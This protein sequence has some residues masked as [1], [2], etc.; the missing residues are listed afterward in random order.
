MKCWM[1]ISTFHGSLCLKEAFECMREF[2]DKILDELFKLGFPESKRSCPVFV[3]FLDHLDWVNDELV[4]PQE[5][6]LPHFHSLVV[7]P[8]K[9]SETFESLELQ[10][11]WTDSHRSADRVSLERVPADQLPKTLDFSREY[12]FKVPHALEV[13]GIEIPMILNWDCSKRNKGKKR[14]KTV[15]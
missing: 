9:V 11:L 14:G 4:T 10:Q 15:R 1:L 5:S 13:N 2:Y 6:A 12:R 3:S 7:C 8:R